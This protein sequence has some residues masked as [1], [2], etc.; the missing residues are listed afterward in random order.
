[1]WNPW[2][3]PAQQLA[4][5]AAWVR[6]IRSRGAIPVRF[7]VDE[8]DCPMID[9]GPVILGIFGSESVLS[10]IHGQLMVTLVR[11]DL[12][13]AGL[14][15]LAVGFSE[16]LGTWAMLVAANDHHQTEAGRSMHRELLVLELE[17]ILGKAWRTVYELDQDTL[18]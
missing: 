14:E 8:S 11:R 2:S 3:E 10:D 5:T 18:P 6:N 9:D 16:D 15:E 1:M 7:Q 4:S 17:E 13:R 12:E